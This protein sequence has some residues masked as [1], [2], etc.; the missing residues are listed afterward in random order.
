[1]GW[2]NACVGRKFDN[3]H[4]DNSVSSLFYDSA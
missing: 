1:M 3:L 4:G 2:E